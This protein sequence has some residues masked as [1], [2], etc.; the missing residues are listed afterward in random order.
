M[1]LLDLL[2]ENGLSIESLFKKAILSCAED[3]N[4][5]ASFNSSAIEKKFTTISTYLNALPQ[6]SDEDGQNLLTEVCIPCLIK[7]SP[8][9]E[10]NKLVIQWVCKVFV[11]VFQ[12]CHT[13][14]KS[15]M[16]LQLLALCKASNIAT[17][18]PLGGERAQ[19][20]VIDAGVL[21]QVLAVVFLQIDLPARG[22]DDKLCH[23]SSEIFDCILSYLQ[24]VDKRLCYQ[25]CS[26]VLPCFIVGTKNGQNRLTS[27]WSIAEGAYKNQINVE[28]NALHLVLTVLCCFV[29]QFLGSSDDNRLTLL[30]DL[31]SSSV[32]WAVIQEGLGSSNP[33]NRKRSAFLLQFSLKSVSTSKTADGFSTSDKVFWWSKKHV[34]QLKKVWEVVVLLLETL[35]E[36][37][38]NLQSRLHENRIMYC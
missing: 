3:I 36:K 27:L 6:V 12:K 22:N 8:T 21:I 2:K 1:D 15:F 19:K 35:E 10:T 18:G 29:H 20:M 26:G 14:T 37:Q 5:A 13:Q 16:L 31:R 30:V 25:L 11:Y 33:L 34:P 17:Q 7:L 23:I 9:E 4:A 24:Y 28:M 38:V 32:L